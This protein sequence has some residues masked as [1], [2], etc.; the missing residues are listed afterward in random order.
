MM[1][2]NL[3]RQPAEQQ[4][5]SLP[6]PCAVS[7]PD[8]ERIGAARPR[9][10]FIIRDMRALLHLTRGEIGRL[11]EDYVEGRLE[12]KGDL[13]DLMATAPALLRHDPTHDS[14]GWL[15]S[16][17]SRARRA[18]WERTHHSRDMD[19][20]QIQHHYDVSD[21]FYALWL[22]PLRVYSCA[23]FQRPACRWKRPSKPSSITSAQS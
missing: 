23:Y 16:R 22:D 20:A 2:S 15:L 11:A 14:R 5:A 4:I 13:H 21:D 17:V 3:F 9:L 19:A 6:L 1:L 8:G 7:L 18:V 12:I 10:S